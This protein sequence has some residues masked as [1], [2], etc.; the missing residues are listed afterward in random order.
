MTKSITVAEWETRD[1]VEKKYTVGLDLGDRWSWYCV[2][3]ERGEVVFEHKLSTTPKALREV[4]GAMPQSRVAL[5]TGTHSPWVSRLMKELGH[6][7]IVAQASKVRLIGESRKKD[8][9]LDARTLARLARVDPELLGPTT[10]QCPGT[11]GFDHAPGQSRPGAGTNGVGQCSSGLDE[12]LWRTVARLQPV[13]YRRG[14]E[15][16]IECGAAASIG[17]AVARD[18]VTQPTDSGL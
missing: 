15:E 13:E 10:S 11:S 7:V 5:E 2:L 3:D 6:E 1:F 14:E 17:A 16:G 12:V 8:D 4:F 18:R 9:R